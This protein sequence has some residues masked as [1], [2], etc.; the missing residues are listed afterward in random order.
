MIPTRTSP[1]R[2][3]CEPFR[4]KH[5]FKDGVF[6]AVLRNAG[7]LGSTKLI[8]ALFGLV[9]LACASH[10]LDPAVFGMLMIVHAYAVGANGIA[11][12]QSWQVIIRY[13]APALKKGDRKPARDAIR[14]AFGLDIVS[15]LLG[16]AAAMTAL[17]WLAPAL[18]I[19]AGHFGLTLFYCTL[20]PTMAAATPTGVMRLLDRF[21]LIAKQGLATPVLRAVGAAISYVF[22]L[23]FPGFV[24]A[25]YIADIVGDLILWGLA[26]RELRRHDMLDALRPGLRGAARRLPD[27]W[28]FVWSTNIATSLSS[29]W[30][31]VSNLIVGGV[32]G[33]AAAGLYGIAATLLD[34]ASKP[35]DLLTKG[36]YPEI[37]RLDPSSKHPWKLALRTG[38]LAG[39]LGIVVVGL[40]FL[41]GKP[42]IGLFGHKYLPAYGLLSLM[43]FALMVS[44]ASAPLQSLL[45]MVG[46]QRAALVAQ[47]AATVVYLAALAMLSHLFGLT[48]SG[49]AYVLGNAALALFMLIP[50]MASYHGRHRYAP[51]GDAKP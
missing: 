36:F 33:P 14:L 35:A 5:W 22:H 17:F 21:D 39:G 37:M 3:R 43:M 28:S 10:A 45:Y 38:A 44:M 42:L 47:A 46:R 40:I 30:G 41:G 31:P 32:L 1:P 12:F 19:D 13:G 25:W 8:G 18:H 15:G 27:A 9:S 50:V 4:M 7:Y 20:V 11:K 48:G 2:S 23:G 24:V 6:R 26:V 16:M 51:A 49:S 29:A 34:S